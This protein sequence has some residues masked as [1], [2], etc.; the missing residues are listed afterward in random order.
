MSTSEFIYRPIRLE[1]TKENEFYAAWYTDMQRISN[2]TYQPYFI[3]DCA[4][5][6]AQTFVFE[7]YVL[8]DGELV[9]IV[10]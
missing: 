6:W 9:R 8:R 1:D 10:L 4:D 2:Y 3:R 7:V 5:E